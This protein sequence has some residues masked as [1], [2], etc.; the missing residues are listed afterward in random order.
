MH[1]VLE[2]REVDGV[3]VFLALAFVR[4]EGGIDGAEAAFLSFVDDGEGVWLGG[5]VAG[6]YELASGLGDVLLVVVL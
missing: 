3:V 5:G 4:G 1:L 2:D 6:V